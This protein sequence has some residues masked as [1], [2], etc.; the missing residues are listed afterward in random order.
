MIRVKLGL[1]D[2]ISAESGHYAPGK[3]NLYYLVQ[4]LTDK[5]CLFP[6]NCTVEYYSDSQNKQV[7]IVAAAYITWGAA[8]IR[9]FRGTSLN[10]GDNSKSAETALS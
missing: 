2:Y 5:G 1:V 4:W 10:G 8:R 9:D 6:N 7:K 3:E